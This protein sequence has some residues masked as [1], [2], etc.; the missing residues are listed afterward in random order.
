M[1]KIAVVSVAHIHSRSF[2]EDLSK[3]TSGGSPYVIWDEVADRGA[4]YAAEFNCPF[5]ADLAKVLADP[6][7]DGFIVCAENTRHLPLL[8]QVLPLGKPTLCEKPL[9][10][11]VA[12][13]EEIYALARDYK[14]PLTSGYFQPFFAA[15]RAVARLIAEGAPGKVTHLNFRNAHHAAYGRWF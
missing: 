15:N 9:A 3:L 13:V 5:E 6:A 7:V 14:T 2:C 10:T 12:D 8:R 1:P 11:T 4:K